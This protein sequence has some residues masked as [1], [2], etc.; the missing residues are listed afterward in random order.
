[1]SLCLSLSVSLSLSLA[2][3]IDRSLFSPLFSLFLLSSP[4][5]PPVTFPHGL[6]L[7]Y[8]N[9]VAHLNN[10]ISPLNQSLKHTLVTPSAQVEHI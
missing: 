2:R 4:P 3:S 8:T 6:C 10:T 5:L 1:M 7:Y 9:V